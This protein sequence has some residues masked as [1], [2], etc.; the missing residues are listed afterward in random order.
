MGETTIWL[1]CFQTHGL[2]M[3]FYFPDDIISFMISSFIHTLLHRSF[4][5]FLY[6][7]PPFATPFPIFVKATVHD[8][9]KLTRIPF[10]V[11]FFETEFCSCYLGWSVMLPAW[12]TTT[13]A[14]WV[15]AILP[16]QPPTWDY[17]PAP[18]RLA[19]FVFL[20]EMGFHYIGWVHLELLTSSD[21]P[22]LGTQSAGLQVQVI[23][24]PFPRGWDYRY[25]PPLLV[26]FSIFFVETGFCHVGQAGLELLTSRNIEYSCP[27]TNECEI[28]KRRRKSCQAC[29]FMK[30]LKVGMLKEEHPPE[31]VSKRLTITSIFFSRASMHA[32]GRGLAL[33][34]RLEGSGMLLA[35]CG[36]DLLGLA[37]S[38]R[39]ECSG[40][41]L[42]HCSLDLLGLALSFRLQCSGMILAHCSLDLLGL[43][44]SFRLEC[45]GVILAHCS[46][47][48]L[49]LA[50]S[51][52]LESS[53]MLLAHCSLDLLGSSDPLASGS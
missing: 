46:L 52:R 37:S 2:R 11:F 47:D 24:P 17:S 14:S 33:S 42:A 13:S 27:A 21:P 18:P 32:K 26:Y 43:A 50:L 7:L 39:L 4:C 5:G 44:L 9:K 25:T 29:R 40:V 34:F 16:P 19:N 12:L 15:Q 10:V 49:G 6:N 3:D 20:V 51:F 22:S 45:S 23:L 30:C 41:I 53:G 8:F 28:T 35:H 31:L 48:L 36:L 38:F 1:G